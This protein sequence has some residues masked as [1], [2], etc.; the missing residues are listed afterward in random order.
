[1][2]L[3]YFIIN[4]LNDEA[5]KLYILNYSRQKGENIVWSFCVFSLGTITSTSAVPP[6]QGE[7]QREFKPGTHDHC[8]GSIEGLV[9]T[10]TRYL[11]SRELRRHSGKITIRTGKITKRTVWIWGTRSSVRIIEQIAKSLN[12]DLIVWGSSSAKNV[13]EYFVEDSCRRGRW[14][15]SSGNA[16]PQPP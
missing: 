3:L 13:E 6:Q 16:R 5:A 15:I 7:R 2:L 1:M 11:Q 4:K 12:Q 9:H 14:A 10:L 8:T